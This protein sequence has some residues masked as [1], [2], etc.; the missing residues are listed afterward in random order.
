MSGPDEDQLPQSP[1]HVEPAAESA[2]SQAVVEHV[3]RTHLVQTARTFLNSPQVRYEGIA[4]KREF[5][6]QKGLN[7]LEIEQL[8]QEAPA[9]VPLVPPRTYPQLPQSSLPNILIGIFRI[10]TW[11]AGGSAAVLL[12][13][14]RFIYP[15]ISQSFEARRAIRSHQKDLLKKLTTSLQS[16]KTEQATAFALLPRP[17]LY[18]EDPVFANCSS[19]EDI[20]AAEKEPKAT[21]DI[22]IL[23]C[24]ILELEASNTPATVNAI[25]KR[26]EEVLSWTR[27]EEDPEAQPRLWNTLSSTPLFAETD[28]DATVWSYVPPP[29]PP[30]PAVIASLSLLRAV[31]PSLSPART[32]YQNTLQSLT[33][34]TGYIATQMYALP[35]NIKF[36][37]GGL[38]GLNPEEDEIKREIRALKGLVLNRRT[39]LP[40]R[41]TTPS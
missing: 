17:N 2:P 10:A 40:A 23:R 32:R 4:A 30:T 39:F 34:L 29:T 26:I 9:Q 11:I 41:P 35:G 3:D 22:T 38:S 28:K 21:P 18:K 24:A 20:V 12:I 27:P 19:L 8:L 33:D 5:L 1:P 37:A 7:G 16:V 13:Y 36:T 31:I 25:F 6:A 14:F 15:R